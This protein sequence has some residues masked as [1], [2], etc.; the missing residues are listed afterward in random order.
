MLVKKT[1]GNVRDDYFL[2][3]LSQMELL[4]RHVA[5]DLTAWDMQMQ[6]R[7]SVQLGVGQRPTF[8]GII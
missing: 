4:D 6:Y 5:K 2:L 3:V 7:V 1:V 8:L